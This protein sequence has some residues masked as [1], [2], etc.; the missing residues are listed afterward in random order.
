MNSVKQLTLITT[1]ASFGALLVVKVIMCKDLTSACY[2]STNPVT[3]SSEQ[4]NSL[5][6]SEQ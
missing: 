6:A 3:V 4:N 1:T 2:H 5:P